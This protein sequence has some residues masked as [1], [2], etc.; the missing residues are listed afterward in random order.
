MANYYMLGGD[1]KEYGPIS[2]EQLRHWSAEGRANN[3]TQ[4][5]LAEDGPW[6]AFGSVM[7]LAAPAGAYAASAVHANLLP[8]AAKVAGPGP[9]A[10]DDLVKRLASVLAASSV[11]MKLF[12]LVMILEAVGITFSTFGVGLILAWIPLWLGIL[13]WTSANRASAALAS[14]SERDLQECL[15]R[16]RFYFKLNGILI[17]IAFAVVVVLSFFSLVAGPMFAPGGSPLTR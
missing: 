8:L 7:E 2:A 1:G 3:Y 15:D 10:V 13:L 5:R 11:W 16:L 6:V 12:A 14:G 4:V 17:I 9:G